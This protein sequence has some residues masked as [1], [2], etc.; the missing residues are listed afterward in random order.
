MYNHKEITYHKK[1][2]TYEF[3]RFEVAIALDLMKLGILRWNELNADAK[4]KVT[5]LTNLSIQQKRNSLSSIREILSEAKL[6]EFMCSRVEK[7]DRQAYICND[8]SNTSIVQ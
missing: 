7:N 6:Q 2:Q 1:N 5:E 4:E 8:G 3:G